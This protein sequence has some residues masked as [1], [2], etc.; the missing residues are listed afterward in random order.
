M[1][2]QKY[3]LQGNFWNG[4]RQGAEAAA[5]FYI[6]FAIL[7]LAFADSWYD[8]VTALILYFREQNQML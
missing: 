2:S 1:N 8:I 7:C 3:K 6:L 4:L 5:P